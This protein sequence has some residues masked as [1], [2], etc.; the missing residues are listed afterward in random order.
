MAQETTNVITQSETLGKLALALSKAQ[1]EMSNPA[2]NASNPFFKSRYADLATCLEAAKEV[3]NKHEIA[4]VQTTTGT[5]SAFVQ[6]NTM[7]IHSSGEWLSS[8]L[9]MAPVKRDPQGVGSA[10]TYARRYGLC[11]ITGMAAE[12]DDDGNSASEAH[13]KHSIQSTPTRVEGSGKAKG[14]K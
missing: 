4:I 5:C 10:I 2:K 3:L 7:L 9:K 6:C 11:A 1:S 13:K 12:D 14:F 8:V